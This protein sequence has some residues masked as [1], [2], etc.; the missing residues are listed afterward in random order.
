MVRLPVATERDELVNAMLD[1][2]KNNSAHLKT[3]GYACYKS[4]QG[5]LKL[6]G[7]RK[8]LPPVRLHVLSLIVPLEGN[9]WMREIVR[10]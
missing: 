5:L 4:E 9:S 2:K 8:L 3:S 6:L 7:H 1:E 10:V